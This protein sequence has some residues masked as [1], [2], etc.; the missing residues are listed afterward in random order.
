MGLLFAKL[1]IIMSEYSNDVSFFC[2]KKSN[3]NKENCLFRSDKLCIKLHK[4][5]P[6]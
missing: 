6:T 4:N 2:E 5:L 1:F 3:G